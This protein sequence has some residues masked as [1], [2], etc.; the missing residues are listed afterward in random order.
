M[1]ANHVDM[2]LRTVYSDSVE[3][4]PGKF[5]LKKKAPCGALNTEAGSFRGVFD[6]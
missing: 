2:M 5:N 6:S 1:R 4:F 3:L